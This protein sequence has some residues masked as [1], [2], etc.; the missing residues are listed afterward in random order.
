MFIVKAIGVGAVTGIAAA[1]IWVLASIAVSL[2]AGLWDSWRSGGGGI[3]GVAFSVEVTALIGLV[4]F[5][6]G[7]VWMAW[8]TWPNQA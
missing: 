1:L 3:A 4:G 8:R 6:P 7:L 2:L 5:F